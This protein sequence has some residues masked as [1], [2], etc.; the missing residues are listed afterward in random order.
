[1][2]G[3]TT[4]QVRDFLPDRLKMSVGFSTESIDGWVTP[5]GL[6]ARIDLKNLFGTAA[7]KRRIAAQLALSPSFP[8]FRGYPDYRFFDPQLAREG[9]NERLTDGETDAEGKATFN[10]NLQRFARATYRLHVMAE[11]FEADGGRG[12]S[13]DASQ[14]VSNMPYLVGYKPDGDL[15]YLSRDSAHSVD[16]IA[17]D[18]QAKRK[19]VDKLTL[20]R[21]E[22]RY[23]SVLMRQNNGTYKYES[24]RK[25]SEIA[26]TALALPAAGFT[27]ALDSSAPGSYAYAVRDVDGQQLAR[28]DYQVAGDANLTRKL[29]KNAELDLSLA[30]HDYSPGEDVELSI[31]APYAGAGLITIERDRVYAWHWFKASTTSSV[32]HIRVPDKL[33]GNAY[34]TV[35]FV[36]DPGSDEIYSSPLSFGVQPF[37]INLDVRRNPIKIEAPTKVKPGEQV[38]LRYRTDRPSHIVLF[39][40]DE[41]ILQVA[42]YKSPKPLEFFFQKR[43]LSVSTAQIL[44][45]LLPEFRRLGLSAAP[46]GDAERLLSQHLNPFRRKGEKPVV[47]WS[48]LLD[49]DATMRD[50]Q[51]TVPD[52]FN[53]SL[54]VMAVAV[55]DDRIGVHDGSITVRGD[56]VLSPNAPTTVV[57]GDEFDVSVGVSNNVAASGANAAV[58]VALELDAGLEMIGD[59][60]QQLKIDEGHESSVRFRLRAR[61]QLGAQGMKF[62]AK[63]NAGNGGSATRRIDLSL[64]PATPYMT[65]LTTGTIR[66]ATR[67]VPVPRDLY[68]QFR[69]QEASISILPLGFAHGFITYLSNY[70]YACT[71]QIVSQAMPAI[72]LGNR[73]EFGYVR[74]QPGATV[75]GLL[76]ELRSRQNDE[77]AYKLWPGGSLVI[78]FVSLYAQHAL[79]EAS[80]RGERIPGDLV[81]KGNTYLRKIA[82]RDGNNLAD[83]RN[84]AF[85]VYLL[86]RQA[87]NTAAEIAALRKRLDE[88]YKKEWPHD[89]TAMWLAATYELL[90]KDDE[91]T[92]LLKG[93][94]FSDADATLDA[95]DVYFDPMTHDALLLWITAKHF[96]EKLNSISQEVLINLSRRVNNGWY[97]SLSAGTTLLALDVYANA[98][99][100]QVAHLSVAEV[101]RSDKSVRDLPLPGGLFPKTAFSSQ[102]AALRLGNGSEMNA[103]YLI[104]QSGFDRKPPTT[105]IHQGMEILR[106]YS[107]TDGKALTNVTM[108]QEILVHLK[109]RGLDGR[110]TGNVALVDLLPGGFELVVPAQ[111]PQNN[112]ASASPDE[113]TGERTGRR[114][115]RSFYN[116][117]QCQICVGGNHNT[118]QYADSREDRVVFYAGTTTDVQ[119]IVYRIKATNVGK[120]TTPPAYGEAM[121]DRTVVARSIAGSLEVI[122]P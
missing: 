48:G 72:V 119:E 108:G 65:Q 27:L 121:Y 46:G 1:L 64:R 17:I 84:S 74:T 117:W 63:T 76:S 29:D 66:N 44:D 23:V 75:V 102:A 51:F 25:E 116:T 101:L 53:G 55:S 86:T 94:H 61:D 24:R 22:I 95:R 8:S 35:T 68:P 103:Y 36:R 38:V 16:L 69:K 118:L 73:P 31:R 91:A 54:R 2:I 80:D 19:A 114:Y 47:Y 52:Y 45:L 79:I 70:P 105:A 49:A 67:D 62:F 18:P 4:V 34:V 110:N 21:I 88:R 58:D 10:L 90:K 107:D 28:I 42:Q 57:P 30:K 13:A 32:Q 15:A 98:G 39:A 106:E 120:F 104:D 37:S 3:S 71:E 111:P 82:G 43:A 99:A 6:Q 83:E 26:N 33:E 85:A 113:N 7:E 109:F 77:G 122:R 59:S 78:E 5:D 50:A 115:E 11:G 87:E 41:G 92:R 20:T 81:L 60:R 100:A 14:L 112:Y 12:V 93:V 56:F 40:V 96:P 97:V 9:F 89:L